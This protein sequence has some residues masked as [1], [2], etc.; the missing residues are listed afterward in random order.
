MIPPPQPTPTGRRGTP[1]PTSGPNRNIEIDE[2]AVPEDSLGS[3]ARSHNGPP[4]RAHRR[5]HVRSRTPP[6]VHNCQRGGQPAAAALAASVAAYEP[7]LV[8]KV[9]TNIS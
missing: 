5:T 2:C 9:L 8:A 4:A 3:V 6:P 7:E 1:T